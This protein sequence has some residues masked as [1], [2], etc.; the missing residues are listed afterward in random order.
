MQSTDKKVNEIT[1]PLY[2]LAPDARSM[3]ELEVTTLAP[4]QR[5]C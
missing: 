3:A 1:P 5:P 4:L 2:E